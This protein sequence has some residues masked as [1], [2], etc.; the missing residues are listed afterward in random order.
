MTMGSIEIIISVP[1][2]VADPVACL[3]QNI[4]AIVNACVPSWL[5][6]CPC[7]SSKKFLFIS[8]GGSA[9]MGHLDNAG[10][11]RARARPNV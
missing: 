2:I 6:N 10:S 8:F 1:I 7:Q 9:I 3:T 4:M 11:R 5:T